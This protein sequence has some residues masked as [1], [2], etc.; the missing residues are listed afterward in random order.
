M[1]SQREQFEKWAAKQ[2]PPYQLKLNKWRFAD[3][4]RWY[5]S[6]RTE[7]TYQGFVAALSTSSAGVDGAAQERSVRT[8]KER[9]SEYAAT[10]MTKE[11]RFSIFAEIAELRRAL[12]S[13]PAAE[14]PVVPAVPEGWLAAVRQLAPD[15]VGALSGNMERAYENGFW[16]ARDTII[17][18]IKDA[19]E[20]DT[21]ANA[22]GQAVPEGWKLVPRTLTDEQ[23]REIV[24]NI[25]RKYKG[26]PM[27]DFLARQVW[28]WGMYAA[29]SAPV[30]PE[31]AEPVVELSDESNRDNEIFELQKAL[32]F[33]L[34]QVNQFMSDEM[35]QRIAHDAYLL[36][37]DGNLPDDFKTAQELHWI[38]P[39]TGRV[40]EDSGMVCG[41]CMEPIAAMKGQQP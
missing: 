4:S 19:A 18:M 32:A 39:A 10:H 6:E 29:P 37:I 40:N 27:S 2:E 31:A 14:L 11:A 38:L 5:D 41:N 12:A 24:Y 1:P 25:N 36:V 16:K 8:W 34:P 17:A 28:D 3:G 20:T 13:R 26:N 7:H 33:W 15:V 9:C 30:V 22:G 21:S 23:A 35:S